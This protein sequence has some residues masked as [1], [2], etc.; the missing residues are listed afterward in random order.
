MKPI[1]SLK[2]I[3]KRYPG[4]V[5]LKDFSID[6]YP[7]EV[8]AL[9][10][11][12][13]A[14]K[15]TLIK[16]IS[17]AI[18]PNEGSIVVFDQ[19]YNHMTPHISKELGI[20]VIYQEFN[21]IDCVSVAENI[22]LGETF[23]RF[24]DYKK[25]YNR[26][27]SIFNKFNIAIDPNELV[28]NIS[29][30]HQQIVEIAKAVSRQ[31]KI[32]IM[33]EP[34]AP[35]SVS[36]VDSLFTIINSFKKEGVTVIYI[37]HRIDEIFR[38]ADKVS[39]MRDGKYV[40]TL[41]TLS[42][43]RKELISLMVGRSLSENYPKNNNVTNEIAL[44]AKGLYGNGDEDISFH[45]HKGEILGVAGLVG[46]GRTELARLLYGVEQI[47]KGQVFIYGKEVNI[48][49]PKQAIKYGIGLIPEDRKAQGCFLDNTIKWNI[50]IASIK[51]LSKHF[52]VNRKKEDELSKKYQDRLQI[53]TPS[54]EQKVNN[55][56]G[57]NQQKVVVAKTLATNSNILIFDEPTRGI[58]VGAKQEIYKLMVELATEG[59]AIIMITSDMEELLGMSNRIIVLSEG[60]LAGEI[61][62][63]NFS[64]NL[65]L[66]L[67][68]S[69]L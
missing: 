58:D 61:Q 28:R 40:D 53:K 33:D 17:G 46:A 10:G 57:G 50:S 48:K 35:L 65:V 69:E 18:K 59:N 30:S 51:A 19:E 68:S 39:V 2:N 37:S 54:L 23:G 56:S 5:D 63:K 66:E 44:E 8:H 26:S 27:L 36:E 15:S 52:I 60:R 3:T 67:A 25:M 13:G 62:S 22:C 9:L 24:V 34:T 32:L 47:E 45:I 4:V 16:I 29:T 12:N 14:G 49:S 11:E 38:I 41:Q 21:L 6:F 64:Q 7:G 31:A 43:S 20:E 1:L 42:T 55:L